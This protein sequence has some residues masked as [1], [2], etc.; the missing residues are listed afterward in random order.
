MYGGEGKS[1]ELPREYIETALKA[2]KVIGLSVCGVDMLEGNNG[3]Q[4]MELNSS[5]GFEGLERAT[6]K[7]IAGAIISHALKGH[8]L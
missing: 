3:P 5:P 6:N 1:I 7:D 8:A 4:V 2:S